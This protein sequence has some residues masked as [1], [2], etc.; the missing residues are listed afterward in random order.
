MIGNIRLTCFHVYDVT[1]K[2]FSVSDENRVNA[3]ISLV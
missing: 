3:I 2:T 1:Q